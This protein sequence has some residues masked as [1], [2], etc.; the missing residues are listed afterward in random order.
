MT[1][2][3]DQTDTG[4]ASITDELDRLEQ[5]VRA[6]EAD[7]LDL[8]AALR[9]FEEGVARLRSARERLATA[10]LRVRTVLEDADGTLHDTRRDD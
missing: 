2:P 10:Q 3:P 1:Q 7:D 5:I 4:A 6:L 9:L 8:D